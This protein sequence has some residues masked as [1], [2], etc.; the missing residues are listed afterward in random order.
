MTNREKEHK[1]EV[2]YRVYVTDS[3]FCSSHNMSLN[4]RYVERLLKLY[5]K[6]VPQRSAEDIVADVMNRHGLTFKKGGTT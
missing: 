1:E 4:D 6:P 5:E 3:L 2:L